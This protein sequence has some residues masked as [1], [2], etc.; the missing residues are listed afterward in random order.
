MSC[1]STIWE[2]LSAIAAAVTAVTV[3]LALWQ[4]L[5]TKRIAQLQFEDALA[6]EY[7]DLAARI[8]TKVFYNQELSDRY[9]QTGGMVS[10]QTFN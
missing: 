3:V 4:L 6:K 1:S 9:G 10:S 2:Q 7:R 8:P 5:V